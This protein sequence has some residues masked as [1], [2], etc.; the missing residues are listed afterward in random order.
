MNF[1]LHGQEKKSIKDKIHNRYKV[2]LIE[3]L[4]D[5]LGNMINHFIWITF[6]ES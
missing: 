4:Y 2:E 5:M 3:Y 6:A 1:R